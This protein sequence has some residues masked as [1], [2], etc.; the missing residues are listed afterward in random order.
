MVEVYPARIE[1]LKQIGLEAV[2]KDG[3]FHVSP[4]QS[5]EWIR[6]AFAAV[7]RQFSSN[8][9]AQLLGKNGIGLSS[10][11]NYLLRRF[12]SFLDASEWSEEFEDYDFSEIQNPSHKEIFR[13][14]QAFGDFSYIGRGH[15]IPREARI[16]QIAP[17]WA[18]IA[19]TLN[20]READLPDEF[21]KKLLP[22]TL[23]RMLPY[24][25]PPDQWPPRC[26][27]SPLLAEKYRM[28]TL[29]EWVNP[30]RSTITAGPVFDL[31]D[32][33]FYTIK[34]S[35][36]RSI[37]DWEDSPRHDGLCLCRLQSN[38][39]LLAQVNAGRTAT[40]AYCELKGD[41]RKLLEH[42]FRY[43]WNG[44][45][46]AFATRMASEVELRLSFSLP[47]QFETE[48][49]AASSSFQCDPKGV[50]LKTFRISEAAYPFASMLLKTL[51]IQIAL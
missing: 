5:A 33:K 30:I 27:R 25:E 26:E 28:R 17:G 49:L 38:T 47:K 7:W 1:N 6:D 16:T 32:A 9:T 40:S 8:E 4:I 18:R 2:W 3:R 21:I 46:S 41:Q 24:D 19:G 23:G 43:A 31:S 22:A 48:L 20:V 14:L 50:W 44:K 15:Y 10:I 42:Y 39:Y 37:L 34:G 29:E 45:T 11:R 35:Q 12:P 51:G 13:L 36:R